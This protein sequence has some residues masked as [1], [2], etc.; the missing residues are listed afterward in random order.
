MVSLGDGNQ[1]PGCE[2]SHVVC[3]SV[4]YT[5]WPST[6]AKA[7]W[8]NQQ[9]HPTVRQFFILDC[10]NN[11]K[12]AYTALSLHVPRCHMTRDGLVSVFTRCWKYRHVH[13]AGT[14]MGV[15]WPQMSSASRERLWR[16]ETHTNFPPLPVL[17][18]T[19]QSLLAIEGYHICLFC[20]PETARKDVQNPNTPTPQSIPKIYNYPW[21]NWQ[22]CDLRFTGKQLPLIK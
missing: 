19:N 13:N 17:P 15:K 1:V 6:E 5:K 12:L 21:Q 11:A 22:W 3:L 4:S 18:A 7:D 20:L 8:G 14:C 9:V 2:Q 16:R 10:V